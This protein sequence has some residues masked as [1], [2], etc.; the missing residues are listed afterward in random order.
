MFSLFECLQTNYEGFNNYFH[1]FRY[2]I[3][4]YF[5]TKIVYDAAICYIMTFEMDFHFSL[6]GFY[7]QKY[8]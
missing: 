1:F 3:L 4:I 2:A 7:D 6:F 8:C 5:I